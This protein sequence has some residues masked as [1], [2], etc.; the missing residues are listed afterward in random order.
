MKKTVEERIKA[1]FAKH[2]LPPFEVIIPILEKTGQGEEELT[3]QFYDSTV[4]LARGL[5]EILG[6]KDKNM[7]SLAKLM[8]V[9]LGFEGQKFEPI[10]LSESRFSFSISDCPMLHVGRD[11]SSN[12]KSKFCDLWCGSGSKALMDTV[13]GKGA[14]A[15]AWDKCLIKGAGKCKVVFE[16]VKTA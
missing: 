1:L 16:S 8:E 4:S 5:K 13:L 10:E 11:V 12:V 6:L 2:S 9:V 3:A 14:G 15:C 7:K